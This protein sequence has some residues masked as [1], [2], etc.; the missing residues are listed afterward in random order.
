M[1]L[2]CI[3]SLVCVLAKSALVFCGQVYN[4]CKFDV[5]CFLGFSFFSPGIKFLRPIYVAVGVSVCYI[6]LL[7]ISCGF[8]VFSPSIKC[9][10]SIHIAVGASRQSSW[11][12][13]GPPSGP[14]SMSL[15][16]PP[17]GDHLGYLHLHA[18][19]D[20]REHPRTR[21]FVGLCGASSGCFTG[22]GTA[23]CRGHPDLTS[24]RGG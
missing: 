18:Q 5:S 12:R 6:S 23:G 13:P 21:A 3:L 16:L 17:P 1:C 20:C 8:S 22:R 4:F 7:Y 15:L 24:L 19:Q 2:A 10:G 11:Q 9:S 14:F